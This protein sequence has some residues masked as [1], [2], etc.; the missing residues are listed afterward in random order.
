MMWLKV[1]LAFVFYDYFM[2]SLSGKIMLCIM[3]SYISFKQNEKK[4]KFLSIDFAYLIRKTKLAILNKYLM[5]E[6]FVVLIHVL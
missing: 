2:G 3:M 4:F 5:L 1:T 6:L